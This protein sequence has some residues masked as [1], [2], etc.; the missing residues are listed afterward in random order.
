MS[1][2]ELL[3]LVSSIASLILAIGAIWLS[4]VF[5]KMSD[6]ASKATTQAASDIDSSVQKLEK[7]FDK[8]YSDTFSMMKDTVSDMRKHIWNGDENSGD[9]GDVNKNTI[10][11]E[12]DR[13]AEEKLQ[14]IKSDFEEQLNKILHEQKVA[15]GKVSNMS[16]DLKELLENVIQ[17]SSVVESEAREETVRSH[18]NK[19]LRILLRRKRN[20]TAAEVVD[21]LRSFIPIGK[22]VMELKEMKEEGILFFEGEEVLPST[23]IRFLSKAEKLLRE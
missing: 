21:Q 22:I 18:I 23:K 8:L 15:D 10:L 17:T 11:E 19:E 16:E 13:R 3:S 12:A 20:I 7:L 9:I 6:E 2:I 14:D 1:N 5:Y 4:F